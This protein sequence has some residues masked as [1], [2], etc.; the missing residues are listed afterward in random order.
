MYFS[1]TRT[2]KPKGKKTIVLAKAKKLSQIAPSKTL[3]DVKED[4]SFEIDGQISTE[5]ND[6]KPKVDESSAK[7]DIIHS[8]SKPRVTV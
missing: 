4:C 8:K 3:G 1:L 7:S 5:D 6:I 2:S